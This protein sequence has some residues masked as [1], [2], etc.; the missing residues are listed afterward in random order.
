MFDIDKI[1][2]LLPHRFPF[3]MVD[4]VLEVVPRTKV[5]AVKNVTINEEFFNGHFPNRPV[6]PGVMIVESMA[7][8]AG[9]AMLTEAEHQGKAP[10]F[11][12]ID[13]ARFRRQIVP[14]DQVIIEVEILHIRGNAARAKGVAK[15][16]DKVVAE[17]I[18]MFIL[19]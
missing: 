5:V 18:M 19:G 6:M 2:T 4:R 12:G 13:K 11:T 1:K 15:V 10:L 3:L 8:A 17:A 14:G 16:N 9:L 7:Q